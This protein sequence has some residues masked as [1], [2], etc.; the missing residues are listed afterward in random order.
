MGLLSRGLRLR[1]PGRLAALPGRASAE[2]SR[3]HFCRLPRLPV[4]LSRHRNRRAEPCLP[5]PSP[6]RAASSRG[7]RDS[8]PKGI[9]GGPRRPWCSPSTGRPGEGV[10]E[11]LQ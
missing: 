4:L 8:G 3:P 11:Q 1:P 2:S 5:D 7:E 10:G 9:G 6:T